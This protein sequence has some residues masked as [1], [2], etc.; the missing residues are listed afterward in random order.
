MVS[1]IELGSVSVFCSVFGQKILLVVIIIDILTIHGEPLEFPSVVCHK[2]SATLLSYISFEM[3][4]RFLC[5][6]SA[7]FCRLSVRFL[8]QN[9]CKPEKLC[10]VVQIDRI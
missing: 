2:I 3:S 9:C 10:T 1:G 7:E 6:L 4:C 8:P 5:F